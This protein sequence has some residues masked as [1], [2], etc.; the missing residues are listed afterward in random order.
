MSRR[1]KTDLFLVPRASL[2]RVERNLERGR[3]SVKSWHALF[4]NLLSSGRNENA[5]AG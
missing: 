5:S 4:R 2:N 1:G 3:G